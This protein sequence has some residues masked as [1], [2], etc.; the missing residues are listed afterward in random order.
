MTL[1]RITLGSI[2]D[3]VGTTSTTKRLGWVEFSASCNYYTRNQSIIRVL[4]QGKDG[5]MGECKHIPVD[6]FLQRKTTQ[7]PDFSTRGLLPIVD[8]YLEKNNLYLA[9]VS[10]LGYDDAH[11]ETSTELKGVLYEAI[12]R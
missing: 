5:C 8:E 10:R 3:L 2:E 11:D 1:T 12:P 7:K 4:K 6:D 9:E